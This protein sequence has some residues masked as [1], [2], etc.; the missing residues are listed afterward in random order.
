MANGT[1]S[2][3]VPI[4]LKREDIYN[5]QVVVSDERAIDLQRKY[6]NMRDAWKSQA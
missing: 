4:E 2:P 5:S 6:S 3:K 1:I